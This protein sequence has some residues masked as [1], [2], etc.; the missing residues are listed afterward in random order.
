MKYLAPYLTVTFAA[1]G[2][3]FSASAQVVQ[4]RDSAEAYFQRGANFYEDHRAPTP[5]MDMLRRMAMANYSKS[6]AFD[7]SYYWS[8]RNRGY[9]YQNFGE[10]GLALAD[11]NRA[12]LAGERS[13]EADAAHVHFNCIEM[14]LKLERWQEAETHCSMLLANTHI[15]AN[16]SDDFCQNVWLH[17][18]EARVHL[19]K[20]SEARRDY[21]VYQTQI[22]AELATE[23]KK[24]ADT[25]EEFIRQSMPKHLT[26][27]EQAMFIR[28]RD[29]Y[30]KEQ[31]ESVN[32]L[33]SKS[34]A[35]SRELVRLAELL[36]RL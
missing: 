23:A 2:C 33:K 26:K 22:D 36:S 34:T 27:D 12:V 10:Y 14:C 19:K 11:Y 21:L 6:I 18:A 30:L 29:K 28:G 24:L 1:F 9:C 32:I 35:T 15:C 16:A 20:Y 31:E 3:A 25:R 5:R 7:S 4:N 17:R 8:Y 13:N